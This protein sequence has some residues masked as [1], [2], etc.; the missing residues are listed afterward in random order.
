MVRLTKIYTRGGDGGQT[1]LG[2]GSRASKDTPR[3]HAI[4]SVDE[5]NSLIGVAI[6]TPAPKG[7]DALPAHLTRIQNDLFDLG[8][9]LCRPEDDK[10]ALRMTTQ[11][12]TALENAIDTLN[13]DLEP[14]TSFVLPGGHP[15][16]AQLHIA[17]ATARRAERDVV[18]L[19]A[20]EAITPAAATYINR[21]SD[22]LFVAARWVNHRSKVG[23]VLWVPG[24]NR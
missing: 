11:Q 21:L 18:S 19:A 9:D 20:T 16:A 1:H 5:T 6:I 2:D 7:C 23:D 14:L 15:L 22:F 3:I 17:R 10:P 24:E 4:G 12:V 8:A 13:A